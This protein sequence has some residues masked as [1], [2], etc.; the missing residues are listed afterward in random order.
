MPRV[1]GDEQA[2]VVSRILF[3]LCGIGLN[4]APSIY[5]AYVNV[6]ASTMHA[7]VL[8]WMSLSLM[9]AGFAVVCLQMLLDWYFDRLYGAKTTYSFR[10]GIG[11]LGLGVVLIIIPFAT[12]FEHVLWL[13]ICVGIFGGATMASLNQ[14]ASVVHTTFT[15]YVATGMTIGQG[16]PIP[17]SLILDF[18]SADASRSTRIVFAWLPAF[19]CLATFIVFSLM[20]CSCG[21]FDATFSSMDSAQGA[22]TEAGTDDQEAAPLIPP[23][24]AT[25][26]AAGTASHAWWF[27]WPVSGCA[28]MQFVANGLAMFLMPFFT[29]FGGAQLAHELMLVR[30]GGELLGR[31][32]SHY[33][34]LWDW[35]LLNEKG[36]VGLLVITGIR[37]AMLVVLMMSVFGVMNLGGAHILMG[38]VAVFY[39]LFAWSQ[40]EVMVLVV[41]TGPKHK[42]VELMRGMTLLMFTGQIIAAIAAI[43]LQDSTKLS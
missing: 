41:Q 25:G 3:V 29:F 42:K 15:K 34:R 4:L 5:F 43:I 19:L 17:L 40:S 33:I 16:L 13:G 37:A 23:A 27:Q 2:G 20:T 21:N 35:G 6:Y 7:T 26:T 28:I 24:L 39:L 38:S 18:G 31:V 30:F 14:M 8:A 22:E 36:L 10:I 32:A 12:Q 1:T 11:L 9:G